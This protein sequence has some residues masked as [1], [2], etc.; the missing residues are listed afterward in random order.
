M[1]E[2]VNKVKIRTLERANGILGQ[3]GMDF[4]RWGACLFLCLIHLSGPCKIS[5]TAEIFSKE[6][7]GL[8]GP[9]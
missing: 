2:Q 8:G 5:D 7:L 1:E 4:A 3:F 9:Q 6:V